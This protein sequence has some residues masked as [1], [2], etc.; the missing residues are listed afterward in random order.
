MEWGLLTQSE[1]ERVEELEP[2]SGGNAYREI[3]TWCMSLVHRA[4]VNGEIDKEL[5]IS[6]KR[7]HT[8]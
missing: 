1:M 4:Y 8:I 7:C 2:D 3:L 5:C 6:S